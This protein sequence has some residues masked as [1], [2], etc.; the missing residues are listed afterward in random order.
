MN[1]IIKHHFY[2]IVMPEKESRSFEQLL[3]ETDKIPDTEARSIIELSGEYAVRHSRMIIEADIIL[4]NVTKIRMKEIPVKAS[5]DGQKTPIPLKN[6][7]GIGEETAFLFVKSLNILIFQY[8]FN[9]IRAGKFIEYINKHCSVNGLV[10]LLPVVKIDT[11]NRLLKMA[12][13]TALEISVAELSS[14]AVLNSEIN[15][16]KMLARANDA[17]K[18]PVVSI[19]YSLGRSHSEKGYGARLMECVNDLRR[20]LTNGGKVTK[21]KISGKMDS[22]SNTEVLDL[23]ADRLISD[24]SLENPIATIPPET[25]I[26]KIKEAW[27]RTSADLKSMFEKDDL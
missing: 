26:A 14:P 19:K 12:E 24:V 1:K 25:R 15:S 22:E 20:F 27:I 11:Y 5:L 2:Q 9:S 8:N 21:L 3:L 7:E 18:A 6:N 23:L 16:I 13:P 10:E 4:G 17:I